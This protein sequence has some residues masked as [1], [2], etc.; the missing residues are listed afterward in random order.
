MPLL[1]GPFP[2]HNLNL[3]FV[4]CDASIAGELTG[5]E[6]KTTGLVHPNA[7]F[8][9]WGQEMTDQVPDHVIYQCHAHMACMGFECQEVY[10]PIW[11]SWKGFRL[12]LVK[13]VEGLVEHIEACCQDFVTHHVDTNLPPSD[14]RP[15]LD[16]L[17]RV[18]RGE[19]GMSVALGDEMFEEYHRAMI[20]R[21]RA[22]QVYSGRK[23]Q[24]LAAMETARSAVSPAGHK[25]RIGRVAETSSRKG[26]DLTKINLN[27]SALVVV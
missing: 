21:D 24:I 16:T 11:L 23:A 15:S 2:P 7:D 18:S 8:S 26:Y 13:R 17:K 1:R 3:T 9:E 6:A 19:Y 25:V 14:V 10:V 20:R 27:K 4:I 22:E 5:I 12:Y